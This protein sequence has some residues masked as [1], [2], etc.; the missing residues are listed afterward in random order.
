RR[1][2]ATAFGTAL[3]LCAVAA[4]LWSRQSV[5]AA[6]APVDVPLTRTAP[7]STVNCRAAHKAL[8]EISGDI[9][10]NAVLGCDKDYLLKFD[11]FVRPG[12]TLTIERGT[13]IVGDSDTKAALVVQPGARLVAEGTAESP[14]VFTSERPP[15]MRK[16]G[17]WG[18]VIVLGN[19]P[20]NLTD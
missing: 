11:V 2:L 6:P 7:K 13:K 4:L 16:P 12:V 1:A 15:E 3:G 9:E 5:D 17:D 10:R 14:I 8:I 18:G 19:A 20:T